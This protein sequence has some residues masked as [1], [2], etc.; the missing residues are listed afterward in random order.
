MNSIKEFFLSF[1]ESTKER[2]KNPMIGA[3]VIAWIA[4]NWRF[5]AILFFS[6]KKIEDKIT[7][8]ETNYF[9]LNYNL[10]IPLGFAVFYILILPY[11][12]ALF[13]WLS[14]KGI[15][16]RKLISKNHRISDIQY[17]QEIAAEEWQLEKIREGSRDIQAMKE[18]ITKLELQLEE[19]DEIIANLAENVDV[20]KPSTIDDEKSDENTEKRKPIKKRNPTKRSQTTKSSNNKDNK[21]SSQKF[22]SKDYPIMK[23]IVVRD[24]AKTEREWMLI[25]ALYSSNFGS[26]VFTR[27]DLLTKY[28]DSN[29]KTI[30][31]IKNLTN[32]IR[33]MVR[34]NQ[35]KFIN[36]DEMLLTTN[37]KEVALEILNR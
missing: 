20:T 12:M 13:D 15:G 26:D 2:L 18:R 24:L 37:G 25:Y 17:R 27:E 8:I 23:D 4:V 1:I 35:I 6:S 9:D 5:L 28:A 29:R 3:F 21:P 22:N 36:D 32:N 19:K 31:R 11:V 14:Q 30:I 10:W 33:R 34:A 16:V 7:F